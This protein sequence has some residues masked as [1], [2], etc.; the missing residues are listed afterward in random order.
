[1][2]HTKFAG[3]ARRY[4][5]KFTIL[6]VASIL[7]TL[8]MSKPASSLLMVE[9]RLPLAA[10]GVDARP[11]D[12]A[13][14][15]GNVVFTE[16]AG[17]RIGSIPLPAS[18]D[19]TITEAI[20]PPDPIVGTA[21]PWGIIGSGSD[22]YYTDFGRNR[23]GSTDTS[24]A[25]IKEWV[26]PTGSSGPRGIAFDGSSNLWFVE[27]LAN[28]IGTLNPTTNQFK[29]WELQNAGSTPNDIIVIGDMV[30]FT[31]Y[32]S[33]RIGAFSRTQA[34]NAAL[35]TLTIKEFRLQSGSRPWSLVVDDEGMIWF[36]CSGRNVIGVLNPSTGEVT[37]HRSI[38]TDNSEPRGIAFDSTRGE[39]WFAEYAAHKVAKYV[40]GENLF[41]EYPTNTGGSSPND[42]AT[43]GTGPIDVWFT[44]YGTNCVGEIVQGGPIASYGTTSTTTVT[45]IT[46]AVSASFIAAS[47]S[48]T[49]SV[50]SSST[51]TA[52]VV[53]QTSTSTISGTNTMSSIRS[54]TAYRLSTSTFGTTTSFIVEVVYTSATSTEVSTSYITT[55]S[56]TSSTTMTSTST[57]YI[58][59][60]SVTSTQTSTVNVN[61]E[62]VD[63]T[64][65]TALSIPN[66]LS[67]TVTQTKYLTTVSGSTSTTSTS[68]LQLSSTQTSLTTIPTT[69]SGTTTSS[70]TT[71]TY[72]IP[73]FPELP[74]GIPG[75][76][77]ESIIAG[78][79]LA[80]IFLVIFS[81]HKRKHK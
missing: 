39:I 6:L 81:R 67:T 44:E 19:P 61:T 48:T 3:I 78:I 69:V 26:I 51:V 28:K 63:R 46:S 54:D 50:T 45:T 49:R 73:P 57:S 36:T 77:I 56:V 40:P 43:V 30:Y 31:E 52:P 35:T 7:L 16:Q 11:R 14:V 12:I 75:Y 76:P 53:A 20:L 17:A 2:T 29:E 72:T 64:S 4:Y 22:V 65:T 70:R 47:S 23:I 27:A 37:E 18:I 58:A 21:E 74:G 60:T 1:M 34:L 80:G 38:P 32:G 9:Y 5:N 62:T 10:G 55:T 41:Y 68:T 24:F 42:I 33:D 66:T 71:T 8:L 79:T 15:S 25:T 13:I 59:T